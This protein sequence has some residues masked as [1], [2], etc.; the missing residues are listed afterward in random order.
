VPVGLCPDSTVVRHQRIEL[1][2]LGTLLAGTGITGCGAT[3]A[4]QHPSPHASSVGEPRA[5]TGL[6]V[7]PVRR[8]PPRQH[9][10]R[11]DSDG[12]IPTGV[13]LSAFDTV[14]PAVTKLD[15]RLRTALQ[16][17]TKAADTDGVTLGIN[18]GWRSRSY[19]QQLL[20]QAVEKYGSVDAALHW[21]A[22][23][24]SSHHVTGDAVDVAPPDAASWLEANGARYG[25]C[26]LYENEPWHFELRS[27]ALDGGSCPPM[28]ADSS[29]DPALRK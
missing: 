29:S 26:R 5:P 15:P 1:L 27:Q 19:Q 20:N 4:E 9:G 24:G 8:H 14:S 17:A 12:R 16:K 3:T 10:P 13:Y 18:T 28:Y 6:A 11:S 7:A 2:V 22:L 21:V 25:L 23:P